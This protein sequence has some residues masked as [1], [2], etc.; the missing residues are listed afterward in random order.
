MTPA[1]KKN[2]PNIDEIRRDL[3][4]Q[5]IELV[6]RTIGHLVKLAERDEGIR[7]EALGIFQKWAAAAPDFYVAI[8]SAKGIRLLAGEEAYREAWRKLLDDPREGIVLNVL[9]ATDDPVWVPTLL[10]MLERRTELSIRQ[11]LLCCL[12]KLKDRSVFPTLLKFLPD[13]ELKGY[14]VLALASLGDPRAIPHLQPYLKDKTPLWPVDNHG[15]TELMCDAV[16]NAIRQ[17]QPLD[18]E[19][20]GGS[21]RAQE[22]RPAP[23][24][25]KP[26]QRIHW[27]A[28]GPLASVVATVII[29]ITSVVHVLEKRGHSGYSGETS[30]RMDLMV[31]FPGVIGLLLG[32]VALSRFGR[33]SLFERIA[34]V[35]G[36]LICGMIA[37]SFVQILLR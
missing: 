27:I 3:Q 19:H 29:L 14:A 24:V 9:N 30:R 4:S 32:A 10:G 25:R 1:H 31:T 20:A 23:P 11:S 17:L 15:P 7:A 16:A 2:P 28:F 5:D 37:T 22:S 33:L 13:A 26:P 12:G 34:C 8:Q 6:G 21:V 18:G 35:L 36:I